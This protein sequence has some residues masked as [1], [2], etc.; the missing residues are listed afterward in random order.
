ML[1]LLT[2]QLTS[3][4]HASPPES[5]PLTSFAPAVLCI[6][7][8]YKKRFRGGQSPRS[9]SVENAAVDGVSTQ[10]RHGQCPVVARQEEG[11]V[12]AQGH[13]H[14]CVSV[15][16]AANDRSAAAANTGFQT[17][18]NLCWRFAR[19]AR[20]VF[21]YGFKLI[22]GRLDADR[23]SNAGRCLR[24]LFRAPPRLGSEPCIV[25]LPVAEA[26]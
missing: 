25:R 7:V 4:R 2:N 9:P 20:R 14:R 1:P 11:V 17:F 10:K 22:W 24:E 18:R 15:Q 12:P 21:P 19:E 5:T 16:S 3:N 6:P 23:S 26:R 13:V 8:V